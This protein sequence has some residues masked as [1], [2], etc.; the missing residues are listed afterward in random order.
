MFTTSQSG[1]TGTVVHLLDRNKSTQWFSTGYTA[2]TFTSFSIVFGTATVISNIYMQNTNIDSIYAYYNSSSA[3]TFNPSIDGGVLTA[4]GVYFTFNSVTVNSVQI[5]I[6]GVNVSGEEREVGELYI[7]E[8]MLEFERN[9]AISNYKAELYRKQVRHE[10]P[11]GG[12]KLYNVKNKF[13]ADLA[14]DFISDSFKEDLF[15]V[16]SDND[17]VVFI[18]FPTQSIFAVEPGWD[19][20][21]YEV[22][23]SGPFNFNYSSNVRTS[24]WGGDL[25]IEET[26][27]G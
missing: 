14:W 2:D 24:G 21:A 7:G 5:E 20:E 13:R 23:I 9:P 27:S 1:V 6:K 18:P 12:I 22:V 19:G 10:M 17:P 26:P 25:T 3:N 4:T 8:R 16:Y 11:D 15:D